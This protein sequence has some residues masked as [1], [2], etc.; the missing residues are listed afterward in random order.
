MERMV[1]INQRNNVAGL[2]ERLGDTWEMIDEETI[3]PSVVGGSMSYDIPA[4]W[5]SV[6]AVRM[7]LRGRYG[8]RYEMIE[9]KRLGRPISVGGT[10]LRQAVGFA[11]SRSESEKIDQ[12]CKKLNF[13][14]R[15]AVI[16]FLVERELAR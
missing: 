13:R 16:R 7:V 1:V 14:S 6:Q 8:W 5:G 4:T 10:E 11:L 2:Y 12:L 3:R 9:P 15:S